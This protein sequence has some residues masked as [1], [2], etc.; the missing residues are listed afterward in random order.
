[1]CFENY[2]KLLEVLEM[3]MC[4]PLQVCLIQNSIV[5]FKMSQQSMWLASV[6]LRQEALN[7]I[8]H[9]LLG[10]VGIGCMNSLNSL[11]FPQR[12]PLR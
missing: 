4:S 9:S 11:Q 8:E 6:L 3:N 1:M 2:I 12:F 5:T 10:A 7:Y